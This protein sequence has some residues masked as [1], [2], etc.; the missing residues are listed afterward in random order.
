MIKNYVSSIE[1]YESIMS[2]KSIDTRLKNSLVRIKQSCDQIENEA[3]ALITKNGSIHKNPI[4]IASVGNK[5]K[6]LFN[7]PTADSINRNSKNEPLKPK[8]IQLRAIEFESKYKDQI[9]DIKQLNSDPYT[10]SLENRNKFL[11]NQVRALSKVLKQSPSRP[12]DDILN[13]LTNENTHEGLN[14]IE[15]DFKIQKKYIDSIAKLTNK[16]HLSKFGMK[17]ANGYVVDTLTE[18]VFLT[19]DELNSLSYFISESNSE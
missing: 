10:L 19:K 16:E 6:S 15:I 11:E 4:Y 9:G 7:G 14:K 12:I 5:C 1:L 2:D 8:Y 13:S 18:E 3:V 17:S